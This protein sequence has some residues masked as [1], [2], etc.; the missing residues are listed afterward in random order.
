MKSL[1]M[2]LL[3]TLVAATV[4]VV[5]ADESV[6]VTFINFSDDPLPLY[7]YNGEDYKQVGT[8]H[9]YSTMGQKTFVGHQFAYGEDKIPYVVEEGFVS[10]GK[11]VVPI[12]DHD[13][14]DDDAVESEASINVL[15]GTTKG[16]L[17]ITV[18]PLWSPLGA[19]RFLE[20]VD[21]E[22][23]DGCALN[24]VVP[25]F[26]T[27]L[28]IGA[29]YHQRTKYRQA[30]IPDDA[31]QGISFEPGTM[32]YAGSGP[33]SRSSEFFIVMP[34]TPESQLKYFGT[35]PWETPFGFV[36]PEDVKNVVGAWHS[37]GDMPPWGKGPDPQKIYP[38]NGYEYL[39]QGFP[40]LDYIQTC[41]IVDR[42]GVEEEL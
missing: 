16:D 35:N 6:A 14:Y 10:N 1:A 33:N 37:Y 32:A 30:N 11:A 27:Q 28:G 12:F 38:E 25:K 4:V 31:P 23:F 19:V 9:P 40:E 22:Y 7:F 26:L 21:E 39:K 15:C 36:D 24:R 42:S 5:T 17:H 3:A 8:V 34:D 2:I 13:D 20:L 18:K 41:D 29:D